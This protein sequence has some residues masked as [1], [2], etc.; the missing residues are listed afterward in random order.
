MNEPMLVDLL[1]F[2]GVVVAMGCFTGIVVTAIRW[3]RNKFPAAN[4]VTAR[5]NEISERLARLETSVDAT[6][7]EVERISEGQRFTTKLLASSKEQPD[8]T[9]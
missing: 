6:A 8:A 3:R 7:V 4:E 9:R 5:L 2:I 1:V